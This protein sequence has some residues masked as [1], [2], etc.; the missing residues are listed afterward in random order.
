MGTTNDVET[1]FCFN[2]VITGEKHLGWLDTTKLKVPHY[3]R[4]RSI[5]SARAYSPRGGAPVPNFESCLERI[6]IPN[7]LEKPKGLQPSGLVPLANDTHPR[8]NWPLVVDIHLLCISGQKPGCLS[9]SRQPTNMERYDHSSTSE[10]VS[11]HRQPYR[12]PSPSMG[13]LT[14]CRLQATLRDVSYQTMP[15][16][17]VY[18][19]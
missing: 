7:I 12:K 18:P 5:S 3:A 11:N 2:L 10:A 1:S 15:Q 4:P 19:S 13:L 16:S 9:C 14:P 6:P 8:V 17:L